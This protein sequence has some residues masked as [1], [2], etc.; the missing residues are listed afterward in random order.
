[1]RVDVLRG[2]AA[3]SAV[4]LFLSGC[5]SEVKLQRDVDGHASRVA[6]NIE[7]ARQRQAEAMKPA[8]TPAPTAWVSTQKIPYR[9]DLPPKF[10]ERIVFYEPNP[11]S[12]QKL[13]SKLAEVT[14]LEI[15]VENDV[16]ETRSRQ[17][18]QQQGVGSATSDSAAS[19]QQVV[20]EVGTSSVFRMSDAA[21][22]TASLTFEGT[23]RGLM[24][25]VA[26]GLRV[27]WR[28]E[29]Q[30][31]RVVFYR[32]ETRS[33]RMAMVPG[34]AEIGTAV[35]GKSG[36]A[37][38][39]SKFVG[40]MSFWKSIEES[41]SSM[42]SA[43]GA[44]HISEATGLLT[45]RDQPNVL[46]RI[47]E[48]VKKINENFSRQVTLDVAVYRVDLSDADRKALNWDLVFKSNRF[49]INFKTARPDVSVGG[50]GSF[51]VSV[52]EP[53]FDDQGN[54]LTPGSRLT[55]L[56][57]TNVFLDILSQVGKTSVVTTTSINTINN[58]PAPLRV[59]R[60]VAYLQEVSQS[61]GSG[62]VT[63]VSLKPGEID[64]GFSMQILPHVQDNGKDMV[65]QVMMT[66]T[67]ID[68]IDQFSSGG[69]TI[70]LPQIS[71]RDF[72]QRVWLRSGESLVLVGFENSEAG[73]DNSGV[74][75]P[76][77]WLLGS[78]VANK[79][80]ESLVIVLTPMVKSM[81][82]RS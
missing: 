70:Q 7:Q 34:T 58:Q 69:N 3:V 24:D 39:G 25:A 67:S 41:I 77:V 22:V 53:T 72:M 81:S 32:F 23:V 12:A 73:L 66:L 55:K 31:G 60:R 21:D 40:Q 61:A 57:G 19:R 59:G 74:I 33:Y 38:A 26:S 9:A 15:V 76:G 64:A 13:L 2:L 37:E 16:F 14:G 54:M 20:R 4:A 51:V 35:A 47:D 43:Q 75:D 6:A 80:R 52:P 62:G 46:L 42:I 10:N 36:G 29:P 82:S 48:Y 8:P 68:K 79:K 28:Y 45:V 44:Y 71:T 50:W 63:Q 27:S 5:A 30:A 1:M 17:Q 49:N 78:N 65:M 18:S 11:T 56:L